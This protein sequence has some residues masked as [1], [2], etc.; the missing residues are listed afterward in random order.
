MVIS[1]VNNPFQVNNIS[2]FHSKT[3]PDHPCIIQFLHTERLICVCNQLPSDIFCAGRS[4]NPLANVHS[5]IKVCV[6]LE[7][8]SDIQMVYEQ[9]TKFYINHEFAKPVAKD[10]YNYSDS[11]NQNQDLN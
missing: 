10:L 5:Q 8:L 7:K 6:K 1:E 11:F 9:K 4:L 2:L 3:L